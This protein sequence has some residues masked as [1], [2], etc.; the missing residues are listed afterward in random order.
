MK[1]FIALCLIALSW[2]LPAQAAVDIQEVTSP[3]GIKAWLVEEHSIPFTALEIRVRGGSSL[4]RPGKR[5]ETNLMMA[6]IEEGAGDL[7]SQGFAQARDALAAS[8]KFD[9][10]L[11]AVT[12]SVRF[13]SESKDE[14]V[15]L[16]RQALTQTRFDQAAIDRVKE[17]VRSIIRSDANDPSE[18]A[19]TQFYANLFGDHPYGTDPNG[20]LDSID[21]LTQEDMFTAKERALVKDRIYVG[22]VGDITADELA[23]LL[24]TLLGDLPE[25]G[26]ELPKHVTPKLTG[27]VS[28]V[29]FDTPQSVVLFGQGGI[30]RDDPDFIPAYIANE[31]LGG[32]SDARLMQEVREKRGLTYGIGAYLVAFDHA[33][34]LVGQFSSGNAVA[35]DAIDVVKAEWRRLVDEGIRAEELDLAKTYLTGA[36]ALRFDGNAPIARI[37]VGMQMDGLTPDYIATRNDKVNAVTL[38]EINRVVRRLYDPENLTFLVVGQPEG[39]LSQ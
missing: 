27:D 13:L 17:Q 4:D 21:A 1:R 24:D 11:D 8:Y 6:L 36:Y 2:A 10:Y 25:T 15:D 23:E 19:S 35:S 37:L 14:A 26:P 3:G 12:I 31:I 28:V 30:T 34:M 29:P 38:E 22:A 16:L 32:G 20:T 5:G 39:L 9:A 7:D 33:E 18:I